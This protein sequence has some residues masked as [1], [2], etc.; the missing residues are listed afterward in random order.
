MTQIHL[1]KPL[2]KAHST[3]IPTRYLSTKVTNLLHQK[4][5]MIYKMSKSPNAATNS[6]QNW[7]L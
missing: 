3:D 4:I 1:G 5:Y 7:Y 6:L 2:R